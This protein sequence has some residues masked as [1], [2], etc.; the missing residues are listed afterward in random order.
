M[1]WSLYFLLLSQDAC[2]SAI[3]FRIF[4]IILAPSGVSSQIRRILV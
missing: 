1:N 4:A 2:K 3:A